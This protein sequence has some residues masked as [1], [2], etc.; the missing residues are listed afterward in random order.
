[1]ARHE[2][3]E[4]PPSNGPF[5]A[6][7]GERLLESAPQCIGVIDRKWRLVYGNRRFIEFFHDTFGRDFAPGQGMLDILPP[8]RQL[9]WQLRFQEV[10]GGACSHIEEALEL[11]GET[12]YFD[13]HYLPLKSNGEWDR[14]AIY[15]DETT[16]RKR[17]EKRL[18]DREA[19]L[20][21]GIETRQTLL[22]VISHDLRSPIFQLNGLLFLI[23]QAAESRDEARLQMHAEDLEERIS[24]LTHTLDN[25]LSWSS[26]QRQ[27]LQ[28][29]ISRF[30]LK[31]VFD[32]AMGLMKPV[33]QRK[34]VRLYARRLR[35]VELS[36]DHEMVAFIARNLI[37]NAIKF[38]AQAGKV[39]MVA[40]S[41]EDAV[42][43]V[44]TDHGVG[45]DPQRIGSLR[46]GTGH[47]SQA[48]TWGER[49][50]GLGLKLCH[51]FADRLGGRIDFDSAPGRGTRV[52]VWLPQLAPTEG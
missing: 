45:F 36:S 12:R 17:R 3:Q 29:R 7:L 39:E 23:Q 41:I 16:Q 13:A 25:L 11:N 19:E 6:A 50:T 24:H 42:R 38:S 9:R 22:S 26:L 31:D 21:E 8:D 44:I 20:E 52:S 33:A 47:F 32:H 34:G 51:E 37:N 27:R 30:P 28:P 1:M 4:Q 48:G 49:G 46:E 18:L 14:I 40:E 10:L 15:F 2:Q 43:F 35:G 5:D